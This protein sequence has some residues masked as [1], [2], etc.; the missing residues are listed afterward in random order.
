MS[1]FCDWHLF[2]IQWSWPSTYLFIFGWHSHHVFVQLVD[3]KGN[4]TI[5]WAKRGWLCLSLT[6]SLNSE[7]I[8]PV[9]GTGKTFNDL[10]LYLN[11]ALALVFFP[12]K[13]IQKKF[14]Q[15][16]Y[17]QKM[18][19]RMTSFKTCP[20]SF[21]HGVETTLFC[22]EQLN[23]MEPCEKKNNFSCTNKN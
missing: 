15:S 23:C 2:V 12:I 13:S 14:L 21:E 18:N 1:S 8:W 22:V 20:R 5:D 16:N 17:K 11:V 10:E 3:R 19:D 6:R 9:F 7:D 4:E